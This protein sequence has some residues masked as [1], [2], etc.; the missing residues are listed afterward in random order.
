M[1][2]CT[3][4]IENLSNSQHCVQ[5]FENAELGS[6]RTLCI[7]GEPWFVGKDVAEALGDSNPRKALADHVDSEDKTD[8]V[9]IRDSIGRDQNPTIIN[10][11]GLYSL[12]FSSKLESARRFKRWVT[13][14]VLPA[15]RKTG[16][17][18][19]P[20]ETKLLKALTGNVLALNKIQ[21]S[22]K[23]SAESIAEATSRLYSRFGISIPAEL[24]EPEKVTKRADFKAIKAGIDELAENEPVWKS[25]DGLQIGLD[26]QAVNK[27]FEELGVLREKAMQML[28]DAGVIAADGGRRTKSVRVGG[29]VKR[30]IVI[31]E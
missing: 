8:G 4:A 16:N 17:Y 1:N 24:L 7:D 29:N 10:E 2:D 27:L 23:C 5:I 3:Q 22:N 6:V 26:P 13:S 25:K 15:I 30:L 21:R 12:I 20:N 9:T 28:C 19:V 31:M 11:S 14:E 18:S